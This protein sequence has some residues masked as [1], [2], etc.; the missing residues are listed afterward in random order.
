MAQPSQNS[1]K[2]SAARVLGRWVP[3]LSMHSSPIA[4][5][6]SSG[7]SRGPVIGRQWQLLR[8]SPVTAVSAVVASSA[9]GARTEKPWAKTLIGGAVTIFFEVCCACLWLPRCF[10]ALVLTCWL[11]WCCAHQMVGGHTMEFMKIDKQVTNLPYR[12]ILR[13]M[14]A[15]K[16]IAGC[17][18]G[19]LPWGALQSAVKVSPALLLVPTSWGSMAALAHTLLFCALLPRFPDAH[20]APFSGGAR[21]RR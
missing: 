3:A 20:R 16:G 5:F 7:A 9:G 13:K 11:A 15:Q 19:F 21:R 4:Q 2:A 17:L 6:A 14:T 8:T 12:E 1:Q 10:C 18:D